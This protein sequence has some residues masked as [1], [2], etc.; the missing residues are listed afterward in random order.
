MYRE[1]KPLQEQGA[2]FLARSSPKS[3]AG[4]RCL[5]A[6][7]GTGKTPMASRTARLLVARRILVLCKD[8]GIPVWTRDG[9]AWLE[10]F[11]ETQVH[12][13]EM[14]DEPW[15]REL[16][17]NK[18]TPG[19]EIHVYVCVYNTFA[20]DM[21]VKTKIYGKKGKQHLH[22]VNSSGCKLKRSVKFDLIILDECKRLSNRKTAAFLAVNRFLRD[23]GAAY[24]LPMSGTPGHWP[25]D[26]WT[27]FNLIDRKK[28]SSYWAFVEHFMVCDDGPFG[29][30]VLEQRADTKEEWDRLMNEYC[31]IIPPGA[32]KP[33]VQRQLVYYELESDQQKLYQDIQ[34]EMFSAL[35]DSVVFAQ[36]SMVQFLRLR[37]ILICPKIL[38]EG[39]GY[40][41]AIKNLVEVFREYPDEAHTV[42]FT[43][44]VKAFP[45]F[46][47]YLDENGFSNVWTLSGGITP[48][49]QQDRIKAYRE[50][51]G[52][53]ICSVKYAEAF[54]LEPARKSWFIGYDEDPDV[55]RQAEGR[56][57]RLTSAESDVCANYM[58]A[59]TE[60]DIRM[61]EIICIKQERINF[62]IPENV[63][64]LFAT[65]M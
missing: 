13:H 51:K 4:R 65:K 56:L 2:Q 35:D 29:V 31:Y 46:I 61:N 24:I 44:H 38:G 1:L 33:P 52:I 22:N 11:F 58:T 14:T 27:Y 63:K 18:S 20:S 55:N 48:T 47:E 17:W 39:F 6:D 43:P 30:E 37:Q 50:S 15:N 59:N 41:G 12:V 49:Q 26:Y 8:S 10:Q 5:F 3:K 19:D 34:K 7:M 28:F 42:I 36:N 21:G 57:S 53:I 32:M 60:N 16:E 40:G 45:H 64:R 54:S 23:N 25:P 9:K 62:S